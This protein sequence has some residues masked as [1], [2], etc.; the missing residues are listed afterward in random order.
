[1]PK[2]G[3]KPA[4]RYEEGDEIPEGYL[5]AELSNGEKI[6]RKEPKTGAKR[7]SHVRHKE[8]GGYYK[9]NKQMKT[10]YESRGI[11]AN[12]NGR[13]SKNGIMSTESNPHGAGKPLK[14]ET[15]KK[16]DLAFAGTL[17]RMA[18]KES[19]MTKTAFLIELGMST[20]TF[21][22]Y[23]AR[24]GYD[25]LCIR[26]EE[27][28]ELYLQEQALTERNPNAIPMIKMYHDRAEKQSLEVTAKSPVDEMSESELRQ[29][30]ES[31]IEKE[32]IDVTDE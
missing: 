18:T 6:L 23:K 29:L 30:A 28:C 13:P 24:P 5:V 3:Y 19:I 4:Q 22:T 9:T 27:M 15:P 31:A 21:D 2:K 25:E 11:A 26:I 7:K 17:R 8:G 20:K 10:W 16:L 14:F 1:M 32:I 12:T